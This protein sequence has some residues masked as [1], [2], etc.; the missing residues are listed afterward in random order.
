MNVER[1]IACIENIAPPSGQAAWDNSGVQIAGIEEE[2]SRLAVTID[3]S[4]AALVAALEWGADMVLTHHPLYMEPK[5]LSRPGYFLDAARV[6]MA[7]GAWLYAAHTSLDVQSGGPA[8]WLARALGLTD[9]SV[10]EPTDPA[11][12]AVG[13]GLAGDL[14]ESMN[15]KDFAVRLANV[16]DRSFWTLSGQEPESIHRVAYCTGSGGSLMDA[17]TAAGA[18]VYVTGDLRYHQAM[19]S[20]QFTIDVGHFSLENEMTRQMADCLGAELGGEDLKIRFFP[21][22]EPLSTHRPAKI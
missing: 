6:M 2:V 1:I 9:C 18:D 3:P 16:V 20:D 10:L 11:D 8:G 14:G 7:T 12:P 4:P 19:E 5:P 15:F 17:A 21:G 22:R 13:F